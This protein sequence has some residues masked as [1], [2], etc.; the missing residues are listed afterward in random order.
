M[1]IPVCTALLIASTMQAQAPVT[2]FVIDES[3]PYVYLQLDHLG[4]RK[5]LH[6]GEPSTGIWLRIVNNCKVPISVPSYG[7]PT[8]D[9]GTGVLD[10]IVPLQQLLA[11]Q[12]DSGQIPLSTQA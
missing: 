1:N 10:E 4:P 12:A 9:A 8:G 3:K 11:V 7:I 2:S 6:Q 5:P